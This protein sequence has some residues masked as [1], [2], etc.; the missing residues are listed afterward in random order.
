V[1]KRIR[2]HRVLSPARINLE[3]GKTGA[4]YSSKE[5]GHWRKKGRV[6][7][8]KPLRADDLKPTGSTVKGSKVAYGE[9]KVK[10]GKRA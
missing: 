4:C 6:L 5:E 2:W 3:K 10:G 8:V 9:V 1:P 7:I